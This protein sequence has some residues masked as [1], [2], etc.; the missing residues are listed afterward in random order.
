MQKPLRA[1]P[2]RIALLYL[3][4][5][6]AWILL[7]DRAL[8]ILVSDPS[9]IEQLQ[10]YK[11]WG[12]VVVTALALYLI[13]S[14]EARRLQ[15]AQ[16]N[17]E[18][19]AYLLEN[20][21]D[22]IVVFDEHNQIT[23]WNHGAEL[24]YGWTG[25]E[26]I[27]KPLQMV[28]HPESGDI[29]HETFYQRLR[30]DGFWF[31]EVEQ[32]RK[33]G[34]IFSAECSLTALD[35]EAGQPSRFVF[36]CRDSSERKQQLHQVQRLNRA[37]RSISQVN[38]SIVRCDRQEDLLADVCAALA[39]HGDYPL[40]WIGN[41]LDD[42]GK[43]IRVT[44]AAGPAASMLESKKIS[45]REDSQSV[46][47][48][49]RAIRSAKT[50]HTFHPV[51]PSGHEQLDAYNLGPAVAL[52]LIV[53]DQVW[54]AL[55]IYG[56]PDDVFSTAEIRLL[57]EMAANLSFGITALGTQK[58]LDSTLNQL[59]QSEARFRKLIEYAP[60]GVG[61]ARQGRFLYAN[62]VFLDMFG[63]A[64]P[65]EVSEIHVAE[66]NPPESRAQM[67]VINLRREKGEDV[68]SSY[69]AIG[70]RKDGRTFPYHAFVGL[71]D[72]PEGP[73]T[74]GFFVDQ[75]ELQRLSEERQAMINA[76]PLPLFTVGIDG[77][78]L[79]WNPAAEKV[80]GWTADEIL[81]EML[82]IVPAEKL[83]E[84]ARLRSRVMA[85]EDINGLEI[86]RQRK[87]G[88]LIE[89]SLHTAPIRNPS[90]Q[91]IGIMSATPNITERKRTEQALRQQ[92][93]LLQTILDNVPLMMAFISDQ[94]E[95]L[96]VNH[97]W[98]STLGYSLED[99]HHRDIYV[100]LFADPAEQQ[101]GRNFIA[102]AS[103]EWRDF[104]LLLRDGREIET[105]WAIV[106]LG[107]G[108]RISIGQDITERK[109]N[110]RLIRRQAEQL[111]AVRQIG[112]EISSQLD[113]ETLL[114]TI[115]RRGL[116]LIGGD[117]GG[118][119]LYNPEQDV[120]EWVVR[121]SP[122]ESLPDTPLRRGE[123]LSG[124]VWESGETMWVDDYPNWAGRSKHY[125]LDYF[126]SIIA[127]PVYWGDEFLGVTNILSKEKAAFTPQDA[128]LLRLF[129]A[130]AAVAIK[131]ARQYQAIEAQRRQ[132]R[133]LT[134]R[135]VEIEETERKRLAGLLHDQVGQT[136]AA[137]SIQLKMLQSQSSIESQSS[138]LPI[139]TQAQQMLEEV[140]E[141]TRDVMSELRPP[142]LED[143]GL[144]AAVE[145]YAEQLS[146]RTGLPIEV[147]G[148]DIYPRLAPEIE[149]TI[150]RVL[151]EALTNSAKHAGASL[152]RIELA[153]R[154]QTIQMNI[155]DDGSGIQTGRLEATSRRHW[156][157]KMMRERIQAMD[158]I[159]DLQSSR[160]YGTRIQISVPRRNYDHSDLAGG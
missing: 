85:G 28:F 110:E 16:A 73:T 7:S 60:V 138:T 153:E 3:L 160:Q 158:G 104:H 121:I 55:N 86:T 98:Q 46:N 102:E 159:F 146:Q 71:L 119:M 144:L 34:H 124:K 154:N 58:Q 26:T 66:L 70:Q 2:T 141:R 53:A 54:G 127:A 80:F 131:N 116:E 92:T 24:L 139:I 142:V 81:G 50:V 77:H 47:P 129:S 97:I 157:L 149:M 148:E 21:R 59:T 33:D 100:E 134:M 41:P 72:M 113:L 132:L 128:D 18:F 19:Q 12:F 35:P 94:G 62:Q 108:Q 52:P 126:R 135:I 84:F 106:G 83:D 48:A 91:I 6:G 105:T 101:A 120:L 25:S 75:T 125:D 64:T 78:V 1:F 30:R 27:G 57:E 74:I 95:F 88:S 118:L 49:A 114:N 51:S 22:A 99:T 79:M 69:E 107:N 17:L 45:W 40:V 65:E 10:T 89:L 152:V 117:S 68:P 43:T 155:S 11:G 109:L 31:G 103:G 156:G 8:S 14:Q 13:L 39:T 61:I 143:Y 93:E 29:Q 136:L 112:L 9:R 130:Q 44:A 90:G 4:L 137:L 36:I 42:P 67:Q 63:Y 96:W 122:N 23:F 111:E 20:T 150:F 37:L 87:D 32:N 115:A 145:W 82:P 38:Q 133:D 151:Q 140:G 56:Q 147:K 123:G 76:S 15:R 5:A